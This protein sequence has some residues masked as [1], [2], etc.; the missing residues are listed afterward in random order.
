MAERTELNVLNHLI[1]T[2]RDGEYGFRFASEHSTDPE[3][4]SLFA[5]LAAE[6]AGFAEALVP[7]VHRLGGQA[8]AV[9][10]TAGA[11][12]RGWMNLSSSVSRHH[13]GVLIAEAE[14]GE[15]AAL[16]AY[17]AALQGLLPPTVTGLIEQQEAAIRRAYERIASLDQERQLGI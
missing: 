3:I 11:I 9:G 15:R 8:P 5:T 10:T 6:R 1:E 12:H 7:H 2:C 16:H 4:K 13:D 14:R 17:E